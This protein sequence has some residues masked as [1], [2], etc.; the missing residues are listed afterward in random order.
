MM[1]FTH[2]S[3]SLFVALCASPTPWFALLHVAAA[4]VFGGT[5]ARAAPAGTRAFVGCVAVFGLFTGAIALDVVLRIPARLRDP[6]VPWFDG[7]MTWGA[8][9]GALLGVH[10]AIRAFEPVQRARVFRAVA[11]A[12]PLWL[13]LARIG[14]FLAGCDAGSPTRKPWAVLYPRGDE[15]YLTQLRRGLL[16]PDAPHALPVHPVQLYEAAGCLLLAWLGWRIPRRSVPRL[17]A[18]Y[19]GLRFVVDAMREA[20]REQTFGVTTGQAISMLVACALLLQVTRSR[21]A[22][23]V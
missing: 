2:L 5:V 14:C 19:A 11:V 1:S 8:W 22:R 20:P 23:L 7:F 21:S 16:A 17:L 6:G 3:Y 10:L 15:V 9:L 18:S 13:A 4:V 12:L